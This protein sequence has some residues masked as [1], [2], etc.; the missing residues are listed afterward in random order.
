MTLSSWF[1]EYV[2][3]PL[4]GNRQ[5][6]A[7]QCRNLAVV[8][9]LTGLWHGANWN[10]LIWGVYFCV[11]LICEHL[12][13]RK[14]LE[15]IPNA[16]RHFYTMLLV[17]VGFLIFSY[18]DLSQGIACFKALFGIGVESFSTPTVFYNFVRLLPL[19]LIATVGATPLPNRWFSTL[20]SRRRLAELLI[21]IGAAGML[22]ISAAYLADSAFSPFAYLNF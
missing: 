14:L 5:G 3:I 12:F 18:T 21:P 16:L 8:W 1:R 2:Y 20:V 11:I 10:F 13:L 17:T 4:G 22:L 7:K 15:K 19:M 9:V 6:K